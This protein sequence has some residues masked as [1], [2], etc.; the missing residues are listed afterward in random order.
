MLAGH[1]AVALAG[2]HVEPRLSLGMLVVSAMAADLVWA[3]LLAAGIASDPS[4]SHSLASHVCWAAALGGTF[5]LG[6]GALRGAWILAAAALSHWPLDTIAHIHPDMSLVPHAGPAFGLGLWRS[7]TGTIVIEGGMWAAAIAFFVSS[8]TRGRAGTVGF[9][10]GASLLTW[11]WVRN[12]STP[13]PPNGVGSLVFFMVFVAWAY[14]M[15]WATVR[16]GS[17]MT[18]QHSM[19]RP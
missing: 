8:T 4:I 5:Y 11:A 14:W 1:F 9:W 17:G 7:L 19:P 13:P 3:A 10:L 12:I 2:K 6:G 15:D 18:F 16:Q